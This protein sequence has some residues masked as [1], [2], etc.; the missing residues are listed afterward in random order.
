MGG[1]VWPGGAFLVGERGP[2]TFVP[3]TAGTI[4]PHGR[5]GGTTVYVDA[6]GATLTAG[7]VEQIVMRMLSGIGQRGSLRARAG[8]F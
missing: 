5:G 7:Q 8:A 2:E 1:P 4:V 3:A 6:R